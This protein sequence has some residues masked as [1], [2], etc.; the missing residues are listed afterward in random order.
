MNQ[1]I[2][3]NLQA[4]YDKQVAERE[5]RKLWK[6]QAAER[7]DFAKLMKQMGLKT[8]LD[9]GGATGI[10]G[11]YFADEGLDVTCIDLSAENVKAA[12]AKRLLSLQMDVTQLEF[13]DS[14][15][16]AV[17][18]FDCLLHLPKTEW[19]QALSEISRVLQPN[20]LFFL[21]VFG[22]ND[23]EGIWEEDP[24]RPKRFYSF[25]TDY[26]LQAILSEHFELVDF[27][28]HRTAASAPA[29]HFQAVTC[30]KLLVV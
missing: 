25:W 10:D 8:L 24:Y 7:E 5:G 12:A 30:K 6:R 28:T 19:H 3:K 1:D 22:G 29:V 13:E 4:A 16:D 2:R 11:R 14:T 26:D 17:W 20:G 18:S 21:G 9:A 27:H 15:F 23:F